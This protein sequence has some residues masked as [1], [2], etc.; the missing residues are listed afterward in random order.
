MD[1]RFLN[2]V[3]DQIVRETEIDYS[4]EEIQFPFT[5]LP[6]PFS[7][8]LS[9]YFS[10]LL[11][12]TSAPKPLNVGRKVLS[13]QTS[14]RNKW[15]LK[16]SKPTKANEKPNKSNHTGGTGGSRRCA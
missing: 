13:N 2:K 11:L 12:P 6:L 5:S 3:L 15:L 1:N 8:F 10:F 14:Y 4:M 9:F 16:Q 7:S